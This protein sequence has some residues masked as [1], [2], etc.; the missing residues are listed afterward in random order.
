MAQTF[1][2]PTETLKGRAWSFS[3]WLCSY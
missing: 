2:I 3:N 1:I